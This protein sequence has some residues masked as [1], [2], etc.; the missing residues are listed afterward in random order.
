MTN[1]KNKP[2]PSKHDQLDQFS[3]NSKTSI[4]KAKAV[5]AKAKAQRNKG[6]YEMVKVDER[7][8]KEV[9]V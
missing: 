4:E 9:R 6:Q 5:L 8:W 2:I 3:S 7:T 1:K